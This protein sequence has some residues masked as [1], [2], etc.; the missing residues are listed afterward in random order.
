MEVGVS[1]CE[2]MVVDEDAEEERKVGYVRRMQDFAPAA[3]E[4]GDCD[5]CERAVES[6]YARKVFVYILWT[7]MRCD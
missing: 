4:E 1:E 7:A 2:S 3:G 6:A 5:L